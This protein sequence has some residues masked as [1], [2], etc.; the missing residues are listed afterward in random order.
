MNLNPP[1]PWSITWNKMD[2]KLCEG[3]YENNK[4][5]QI[6]DGV[7]RHLLQTSLP[8]S[9]A[10]KKILASPFVS[11]F[12]GMCEELNFHGTSIANL[13]QICKK[14]TIRLVDPSPFQIH[15]ESLSQ[16]FEIPKNSLQ[17]SPYEVKTVNNII[18]RNQQRICMH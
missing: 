17:K 18:D 8:S 3:I 7:A 12:R 16:K 2:S 1:N 15:E 14:I 11:D 6:C 4:L 5:S 9:I 10:R 13:R